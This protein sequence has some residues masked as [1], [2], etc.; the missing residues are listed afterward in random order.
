MITSYTESNFSFYSEQSET[1]KD[2]LM[3]EGGDDDSTPNGS[4]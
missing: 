2:N 4:T 1:S 3:G